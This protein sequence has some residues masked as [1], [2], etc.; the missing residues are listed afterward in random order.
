VPTP[1]LPNSSFDN[2]SD[3]D[4][5]HSL[6]SQIDFTENFDFDLGLLPSSDCNQEN[7]LPLSPPTED[8]NDFFTVPSPSDQTCLSPNLTTDLDYSGANL[9]MFSP[10]DGSKW[11]KSNFLPATSP[12]RSIESPNCY[13]PSASPAASVTSSCPYSPAPRIPQARFSSTD[14]YANSTSS[15]STSLNLKEDLKELAELQKS[16][17]METPSSVDQ[18]HPMEH[19]EPRFDMMSILNDVNLDLLEHEMRED[20]K[21]QCSMLNIHPDPTCWSQSEVARWLRQKMQELKIPAASCQ[22]A[23]QWAANFE[24]KGLVQITEQEFKARF[25]QGGDQIYSALEMWR[26]A[27][28]Y[29]SESNQV[30]P[31]QNHESGNSSEVYD[32]ATALEMFDGVPEPYVPPPPEYSEV[33]SKTLT[34][35]PPA[36]CFAEEPISH[37]QVPSSLN[38]Q[39]PPIEELLHEVKAPPP[40]PGTTTLTNLQPLSSTATHDLTEGKS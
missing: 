5:T 2:P 3:F 14:S 36:P 24:G 40:Y 19:Q 11:T 1:K 13:V 32:L 31:T 34:P 6:T 4:P 8:L 37:N 10:N 18:H 17:K 35:L 12:A 23:L 22:P 33:A 29:Q 28:L 26:N 16:M 27:A 25:P 30:Q 7:N 21:N 9:T 38:T 15:T 39:M 20:I